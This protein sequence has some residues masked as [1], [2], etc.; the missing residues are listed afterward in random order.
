[1]GEEDSKS[2]SEDSGPYFD[3]FMSP[4]GQHFTFGDFQNLEIQN[5]MKMKLNERTV[6]INEYGTNMIKYKYD[7]LAVIEAKFAMAQE[8]GCGEG[9]EPKFDDGSKNTQRLTLMSRLKLLKC[10]HNPALELEHRNLQ[11]NGRVR[12]IT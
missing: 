11:L 6:A 4:G 10:L 7:P 9:S 8:K 12:R 5:I 2:D 3:D 1:M